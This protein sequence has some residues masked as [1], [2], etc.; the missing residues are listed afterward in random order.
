MLVSRTDVTR[1]ADVSVAR[2]REP[3]EHAVERSL[4]PQGFLIWPSRLPLL[5]LVEAFLALMN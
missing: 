2:R 1:V 4:A 3:H 5:P